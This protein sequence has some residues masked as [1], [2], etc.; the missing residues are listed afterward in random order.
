[1][2]LLLITL[3]L[4]ISSTANSAAKQLTCEIEHEESLETREFIFDT[5]DFSKENPEA[6]TVLTKTN[7]DPTRVWVDSEDAA[8]LGIRRTTF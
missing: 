6:D 1:M 2:R 8:M 7:E 5:D 3:G 4:L